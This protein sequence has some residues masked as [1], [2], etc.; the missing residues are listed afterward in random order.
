MSDNEVGYGKPPKKHQFKKGQSGNPKGRPYKRRRADVPSQLAKDVLE[1]AS[2]P[3]DVRTSSGTRKTSRQQAIIMSIANKAAQGNP[4]GI[5]IWLELYQN[6][7]TEQS[8][9]YAIVRLVEI[10]L[11]GADNPQ[12]KTSKQTIELLDAH[13]KELDRSRRGDR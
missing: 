13:I 6:A 2:E 11:D 1:V 4:T 10:L 3:V 12:F 7:V 5:R 9:K 8:E